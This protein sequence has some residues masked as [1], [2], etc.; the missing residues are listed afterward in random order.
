MKFLRT[1]YPNLIILLVFTAGVCFR[2]SWY[3]DLRLSTANAETESYISASRAS[4]FSWKIFAGQRLFTTNLIYKMANDSA[5]CPIT[6]YGK[7]GIG[8]EAERAAQPCFDRIAL[9]QN[10]LAIFGWCFLGWMLARRLRHPFIKIMAAALV[11]LFGFTPQIAESDSVLSPESLSLSLFAVTLGLAL[12]L[13]ISAAESDAP[14]KTRTEKALL[15]VWVVTFLL[16]VFVRDVHLY[17]MPVTLSLFVPLFLLKKFR[18]SRPVWVVF[19]VLLLFF[20]VGFLSAQDG[21]RAMIPVG[22]ALEEYILPYQARVEYFNER[23]MPD[24]ESPEF[25]NWVQ[26]NGATVY[27]VFLITHPG[28]IVSTL[29]ENMELLNADFIQPYFLTDEVQHREFLLVIGEM[30]NPETGAV[31]VLGA[32]LLINLL[33]QAGGKRTPLLSA[34]AW[35]AVWAYGAAAAT[36]LIS[37]FGDT[38]GLRR[39]IMP[40]VEMFRLYMWVFLLPFLDMSLRETRNP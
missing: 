31:Y 17:A 21:R 20:A 11:M 12:D 2:A 7:P 27:G 29:W 4:I 33:V 32:V 15:S 40:S 1:H 19:I 22:H 3:G 24:V 37:Y 13:V 23:G 14:F 38:A 26:A 36:L 30:V 18:D 8:E 5:N 10:I 25:S 9:L 39:H 28:F 34:W 16:W 6:S 35:L